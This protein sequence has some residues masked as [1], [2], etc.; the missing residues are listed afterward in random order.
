MYKSPIK[1]RRNPKKNVCDEIRARWFDCVVI[2]KKNLSPVKYRECS[3]HWVDFINCTS[4][5]K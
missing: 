2:Y 3:Q 5:S 4:K 1:L